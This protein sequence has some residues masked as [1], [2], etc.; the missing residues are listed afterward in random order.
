[1]V[2]AIFV[3]LTVRYR[4]PPTVIENADAMPSDRPEMCSCLA[5]AVRTLAMKRH[6]IGGS[7]SPKNLGSNWLSGGKGT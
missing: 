7:G 5:D 2:R 4:L 3:N 1:M 6:R